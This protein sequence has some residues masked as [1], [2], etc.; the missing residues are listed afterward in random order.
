MRLRRCSTTGA[1][2]AWDGAVEDVRSRRDEDAVELVG[3][4]PRAEEIER[5]NE[6]RDDEP[7]PLHGTSACGRH[8]LLR[9]EHS[10]A[11]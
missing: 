4:I 9:V 8:S 6:E 11:R 10:R 2:Y 5:D 1:R 3:E 7:P